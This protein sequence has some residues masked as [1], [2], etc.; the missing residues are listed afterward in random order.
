MSKPFYGTPVD[1]IWTQEKFY[2]K[3]SQNILAVGE[4]RV[5]I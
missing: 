3:I 5:S 2:N 4:Q 1:G